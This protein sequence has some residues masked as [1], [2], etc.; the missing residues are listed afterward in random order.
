MGQSFITLNGKRYDAKTGAQLDVT[1]PQ[2]QYRWNR[3]RPT[4]SYHTDIP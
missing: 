2:P 3:G 4:T 1:P